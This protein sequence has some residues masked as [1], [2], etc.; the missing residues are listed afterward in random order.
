MEAGIYIAV[1]KEPNGIDPDATFTV[2]LTVRSVT[3]DGNGG[4]SSGA[5]VGIVAGGAALLAE[6]TDQQK[7]SPER[8]ARGI[9]VRL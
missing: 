1:L 8:D 9:F 4:L 7:I 2:T 6:K 3:S 5:I